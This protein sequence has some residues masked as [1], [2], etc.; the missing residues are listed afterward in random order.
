MKLD[1]DMFPMNLNVII[2]K[3]KKIFVWTSQAEST[4]GKNMIV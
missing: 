4:R 2:F 3:E 1:T